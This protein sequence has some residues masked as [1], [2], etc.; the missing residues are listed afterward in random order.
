[1]HIAGATDLVCHR[2]SGKMHA[3]AARRA[4]S[5]APRSRPSLTAQQSRRPCTPCTCTRR[6]ADPQRRHHSSGY[7]VPN[8]RSK[9]RYEAAAAAGPAAGPPA[10]A[11]PARK[12]VSKRACMGHVA[13]AAA[14]PGAPGRARRPRPRKRRRRP[15]R[16]RCPRRSRRPRCRAARAPASLPGTSCV[17]TPG[18]A[19]L[20]P[21][22]KAAGSS[23]VHLGP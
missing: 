7:A 16:R 12:P 15:A 20:L 8:R 10:H 4:S 5:C 19:R 9:P 6:G 1:M 3:G 13:Q 23:R 22:A 14:P 21:Q 2:S 17:R 18:R 11:A